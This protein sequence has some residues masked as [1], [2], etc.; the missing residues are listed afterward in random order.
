MTNKRQDRVTSFSAKPEDKD[1]LA[2]IAK[3]KAHC[4]KTGISFSHLVIQAIKNLN[5]ELGIK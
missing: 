1:G 5:K 2:E 3:L 4:D